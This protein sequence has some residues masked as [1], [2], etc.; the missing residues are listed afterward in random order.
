MV[1]P[2]CDRA[3][4]ELDGSSIRCAVCGLSYDPNQELTA[5]SRESHAADSLYRGTRIVRKCVNQLGSD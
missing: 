1:C 4:I 3:R 2:R 5:P